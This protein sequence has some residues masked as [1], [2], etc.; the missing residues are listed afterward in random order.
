MAY[1]VVPPSVRTQLADLGLFCNNASVG[2]DHIR[3]A[4]EG[5][6]RFNE[7]LLHVRVLAQIGLHG[8]RFSLA[9][10]DRLDFDNGLL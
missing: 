3:R 8:Y 5:L 10:V 9:V 4:T 2:H 7:K 6:G 1:H